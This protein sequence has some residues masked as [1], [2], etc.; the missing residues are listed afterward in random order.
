MQS[1]ER[2]LY[3]N[4]FRQDCIHYSAADE[5]S[6]KELWRFYKQWMKDVY[7]TAQKMSMAD[8]TKALNDEYGVPGDGVTYKRI[9]VFT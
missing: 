5:V 8:F 9:T 3:F 2:Q 1:I 4:K 7:P 6:L